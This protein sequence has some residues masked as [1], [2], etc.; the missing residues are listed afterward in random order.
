MFSWNVYSIFVIEMNCSRKYVSKWRISGKQ[1]I[2]TIYTPEISIC[3][4]IKYIY[5]LNIRPIK[6]L[7][8]TG[9]IRNSPRGLPE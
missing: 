4:L 8:T 6:L 7:F 9:V 1:Y 2:A 5:P 3:E